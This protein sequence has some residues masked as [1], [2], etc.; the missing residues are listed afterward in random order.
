LVGQSLSN[1]HIDHIKA[2]PVKNE[3]VVHV[4]P[5]K[6]F[7]PA[8]FSGHL[9]E[10]EEKRKNLP[11]AIAFNGRI[12]ATT[13]T[14]EWDGKKIFFQ[15]YCRL[16]LSKKEEMFSACIG[17]RRP[18]GLYCRWNGRLAPKTKV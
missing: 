1:L 6:G 7:L 8:L 9:I 3:H 14:S 11:I 2:L 17:L 16:Q 12:W 5:E 4:N 13:I 10:I 15:Y 18:M